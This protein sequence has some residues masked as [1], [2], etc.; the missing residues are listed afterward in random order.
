MP[1]DEQFAQVLTMAQVEVDGEFSNHHLEYIY[2]YIPSGK[3]LHNN[4]GKSPFF[5]GK[6][7][8]KYYKYAPFSIAM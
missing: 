3:R 6:S 1:Q 5:I 7:T 4:Y 2:E 8:I